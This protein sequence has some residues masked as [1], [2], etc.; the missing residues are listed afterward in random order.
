MFVDHT[1]LGIF[2]PWQILPLILI[3]GIIVLLIPIFVSKGKKNRLPIILVTIFLGWTLVGWIG[4]LIW[5]ILSPKEELSMPYLYACQ[6]CGYKRGFEFPLK[7][8]K[9]PQCGEENVI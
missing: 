6:K 7:M 1:I 5:A 4:A 3:V 2:G 8:F 9:C